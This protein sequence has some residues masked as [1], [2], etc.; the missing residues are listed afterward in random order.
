MNVL[1]LLWFRPLIWKDFS[2]GKGNS[3]AFV[4]E[5]EHFTYPEA[6]RYLARKYNIEIEETEQTNEE[7]ANTDIREC[8]WFL[9]LQKT[10]F[11]KHFKIRGRKTIGLSYFKERGFT[12]ETIEKF[13]L[14]Y[15]PDTWDAFTKEALGKGYKLEFLE[16][17]FNNSGR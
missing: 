16:S 15:S 1:H 2:S 5:H 9:N 6:I 7:K 11:I 3:V 10:I 8:I 17:R 4:M 12:N 13:S 14:G